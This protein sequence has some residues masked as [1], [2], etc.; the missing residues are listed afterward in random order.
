MNFVSLCIFLHFL[1]NFLGTCVH[2]RLLGQQ[3]PVPGRVAADL[4]HHQ[5]AEGVGAA[6]HS[7]DAG[8]Q[9]VRRGGR[10]PGGQ[11][12]GGAGGGGCVGRLLHGDLCQDQPQ[13]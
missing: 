6:W 7:C 10:G 2:P 9:Q 13:R 1:Y 12:Y 8:R 11:R 3:S 4:E 5:G